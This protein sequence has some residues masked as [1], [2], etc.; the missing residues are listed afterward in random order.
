MKT[1]YRQPGFTLV[2]LV[3][4]IVI[5][6][7]LAAVVGPRFFGTQGFQERGYF[8]EVAA[9]L[10][11]AQKLSIATQCPVQVN[12]AA[13]SYGLFFPDNSDGNPTTCDLPAVYGSNPVSVPASGDVF[14]K[15]APSGVNIS[16]F[17][18]VYN[19]Q[20]LPSNSGAITIGGRTLT[21]EPS[22][23]VHD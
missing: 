18:V 13:N 15:A 16:D 1:A 19:A 4:T 11:Y 10:R 8:D 21:V 12:I 9:A 3:I 5:I 17:V 23:Y 2:E 7:I 20:G 14:G 6:G 22:G